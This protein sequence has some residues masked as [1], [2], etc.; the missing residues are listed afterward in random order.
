MQKEQVQI[1]KI[2]LSK[3]NLMQAEKTLLSFLHCPFLSKFKSEAATQIAASETEPAV[4]VILYM[5]FATDALNSLVRKTKITWLLGS[6]GF[7]CL[8][9]KST[10]EPN[11]RAGL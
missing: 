9:L 6:L 7:F 8:N 10:I 1:L 3:V 4:Q 2:M 5:S 11:L